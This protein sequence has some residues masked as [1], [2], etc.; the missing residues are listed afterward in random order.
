VKRIAIVLGSQSD[1]EVF[2]D[3]LKL[4]DGYQIPYELKII[5]AHRNLPELLKFIQHFEEEDGEIVIA[6][7][8]LAAHLPGV[9]AA[10]T[11]LPV[12]GVPVEAGALH[13]LDALLS[14]VQMPRGTPV[15]T[16][17]IGKHGAINA[18]LFALRILALK[19]DWAAEALNDH[20][21]TL[22]GQSKEAL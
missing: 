13:G 2:A 12:I 3:V 21:A 5:S 4:L 6:G 11:K 17:A 20:A 1:S 14:I 8:G 19:Y 7:A 22:R 18:A 9:I 10:S 15:A 16:M